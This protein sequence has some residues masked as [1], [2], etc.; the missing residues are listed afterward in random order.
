MRNTIL[1]H[2]GEYH[3]STHVTDL[4]VQR[5]GAEQR[6]CGVLDSQGNEYRGIAVILATGHSARDIYRLFSS[7]GW[8]LQP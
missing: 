8:L 5:S 2:G 1:G 4:L 7:K 3:F 6:V